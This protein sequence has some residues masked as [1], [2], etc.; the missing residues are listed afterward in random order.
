[1][2]WCNP[3]TG[4]AALCIFVSVGICA[5]TSRFSHVAES[6]AFHAELQAEVIAGTEVEPLLLMTNFQHTNRH[7]MEDG[8]IEIN[9]SMNA[10]HTMRKARQALA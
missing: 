8:S 2:Q 4:S 1:M 7:A 6:K 3:P 10:D 9:V 5:S